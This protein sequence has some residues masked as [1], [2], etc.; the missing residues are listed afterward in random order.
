MAVMTAQH[1]SRLS[2]EGADLNESALILCPTK[3]CALT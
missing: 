1:N 3:T 2:L